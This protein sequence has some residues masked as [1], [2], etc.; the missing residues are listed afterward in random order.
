M[1]ERTGSKLTSDRAG[2]YKMQTNTKN[3]FFCVRNVITFDF[4]NYLLSRNNLTMPSP[5]KTLI[6]ENV[7]SFL[8]RNKLFKLINNR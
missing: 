8:S 5:I 4:I 2:Q 1:K 7:L 6:P 3:C